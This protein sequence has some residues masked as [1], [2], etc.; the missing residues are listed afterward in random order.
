MNV[1]L[2]G[3]TH[4]RYASEW[5]GNMFLV[6]DKGTDKFS[7]GH[8]IGQFWSILVN[9]CSHTSHCNGKDALWTIHFSDFDFSLRT[10]LSV[11]TCECKHMLSCAPIS[12]KS[13]ISYC[14]SMPCACLPKDG[15]FRFLSVGKCHL[16]D[17]FKSVICHSSSSLWW[18]PFVGQLSV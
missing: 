15:D 12:I 10:T 5:L 3:C 18:T 11:A 2:D 1:L 16:A 7:Y 13:Q 4:V 6:G 14:F 8:N 17:F 9:E